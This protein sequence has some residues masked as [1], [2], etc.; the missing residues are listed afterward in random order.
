MRTYDLPSDFLTPR[1][2]EIL[3]LIAKGK[4]DREI[5]EVLGIT[6]R[7]VWSHLHEIYGRLGVKNRTEATRFA[8]D[9]GLIK[10]EEEIEETTHDRSGKLS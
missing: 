9:N 8:L 2:R 5:A 10:C 3:S 7:T 4:R 6:L 1:Q